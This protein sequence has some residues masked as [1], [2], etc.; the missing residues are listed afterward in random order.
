MSKDIELWEMFTYMG[1]G[2]WRS[3]TVEWTSEELATLYYCMHMTLDITENTDIRHDI[4]WLMEKLFNESE[5][6]D[7]IKDMSHD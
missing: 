4:V 2:K 6:H 7:P 3:A 5:G 1:R